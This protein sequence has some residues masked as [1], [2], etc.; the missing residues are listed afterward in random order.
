MWIPTPVY[1]RT[2]HA[3]LVIGLVFMS[4]GLYLGF[5]YSWS[6]FYFC[7]GVAC[8][9]F[10]MWVFSMRLHY[11]SRKSSKPTG[12]QEHNGSSPD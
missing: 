8:C 5:S 2:P 10:S 7:V 6:Y 12:V 1:E 9:L 4:S 3:W 11:R